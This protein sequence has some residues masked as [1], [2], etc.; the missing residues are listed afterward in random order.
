[1]SIKQDQSFNFISM[2]KYMKYPSQETPF[3]NITYNNTWQHDDVFTQ[4]RLA[5]L[6]PMSLRKMT[7]KGELT[8]NNLTFFKPQHAISGSASLPF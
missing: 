1:M 8:I 5:G 6:N 3:K 4:Q 7:S 2:E